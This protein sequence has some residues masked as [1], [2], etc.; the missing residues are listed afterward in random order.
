MLMLFVVVVV[1]VVVVILYVEDVVRMLQA[2]LLPTLCHWV[3]ITWPAARNS[4]RSG[5]RQRDHIQL[6]F[7][8]LHPSLFLTL[9]QQG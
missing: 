3:L 7:I 5:R 4:A 8:S 6:F 9:R 2:H 1:V